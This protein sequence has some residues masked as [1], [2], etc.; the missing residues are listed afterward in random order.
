M[1]EILAI[2]L[3]R[4]YKPFFLVGFLILCIQIFLAYKSLRIPQLAR[5]H[6]GK[7]KSLM[8]I[9]S[10]NSRNYNSVADD[11]DA[12]NSNL[13]AV[14]RG[15]QKSGASVALDANALGFQASCEITDN[16]AV[17]ALQR[18]KTKECRRRIADIRCSIQRGEFYASR[19]P[20]YCPAGNHVAGRSLGCYKD[21]KEFRLLAGYY[22][23]FKTNNSPRKCIYLCLQ[24]GFPYAGVQHGT[25]CFCG[26]DEP[27]SSA[28]LP[29][30]SCN[31][32]CSGD[33]KE[34]CGGYFTMNVFE[35]GI[36][37]F[38]PQP[39][40][41]V[42]PMGAEPVRVAFLLTL[43]GRALRQ[44]HRLIKALYS[45]NHFFYIHVDSRQDYLYRELLN[46]EASFPN[47]RLARRRFSTIWG[48][49]S[50]LTM[51]LQCMRDLFAS[52]WQWD[53][54]I[55]LSESDFPVK[56]TERLIKFLT[57]NR[58]RNFVKCHGK[59]TQRFIQKQ[60]LDKTFVECENH[61]WR[62]SDREL[63]DGI[64]F[65]GGSD[66]VG[67]S[68]NFVEYLT[69]PDQ[70]E[71]LAGLLKV[72]Q[73]TLLPA[74]SFFHTVLRNSKFCGTYVDNNLHITNWNRRLGC[75]CQYKHIVD[76]CG[77]SPNDFKSEDW[78]RIMGTEHKYLFFARKFEAIINQAIILQIEEWLFGPYTS[79][80]A[81]LNAYWQNVYHHQDRSP[82]PDD[83]AL[84]ISNSLMRLIGNSNNF[85]PLDLKEITN[86]KLNDE[87]EGFILR[88][89]AFYENTTIELETRIRPNHTWQASRS[90]AI[91]KRITNFEVSTD[92]D[93]KEQITRNF[94][95]FMGPTSEP[96]LTFRF[97]GLQQNHS[98]NLSVL[99]VDPNGQLQDFN[100]LHIEDS[101]SETI[102]FSKSNL[103]RP[104]T[105]GMWTVKLISKTQIHA[106]T[107]FL[108][109]PLSVDGNKPIRRNRAKVLNAGSR[110]DISY[111][112]SWRQYLL[113]DKD[114]ERL[115][116]LASSNSKKYDE[117]LFE[118][119]DSL[120]S[121]FFLIRGTC[122]IHGLDDRSNRFANCRDTYWSSLAPDPK[123]DVYSLLSLRRR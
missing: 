104:L 51:L 63:P 79:D 62:I 97:T 36:S 66:W 35:T 103:K 95:K 56:T 67:L 88:Y 115:K 54:V 123:S 30:P 106:Q 82:P 18:A 111:P 90:S 23:N 4:R 100:E 26:N 28:K 16:Q 110:N 5:Q 81:N 19:L 58:G 12:N 55:N 21:E 80:Y 9:G 94:P 75:K 38:R 78:S 32:K 41:T 70:D 109:T 10:K 34:S 76:W 99:W 33:S 45:P 46:L 89:T 98:Y 113:S 73:H 22:I 37:R 53:F 107:K 85:E 24:S 52:D 42:A 69:K 118:W 8:D 6:D 25:E 116:E 13:N 44:V 96:V 64:Q 114:T 17:S 43:N 15:R 74:E 61:M 7:S 83:V 60:G 122:S 2:R 47:I 20:N 14:A 59:E 91:S 1:S 77:C 49:A 68:R 87:Y 72:Y 117:S 27:K 93:Q 65:D 57:A 11:E 31:M 29:D 108:V 39:A 92:F 102:N 71:M 86:F 3:L 50:L 112:K 40:E 121:K 120:V 84:T 119:I 101:Q 48:G 105:P